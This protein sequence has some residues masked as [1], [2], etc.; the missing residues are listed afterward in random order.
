M[1]SAEI[2]TKKTLKIDSNVL[3]PTA[4]LFDVGKQADPQQVSAPKTPLFSTSAALPSVS[5]P[6]KLPKVVLD[7]CYGNRLEKPE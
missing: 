6:M 3:A 5:V 1:P 7:N 4:T 2:E